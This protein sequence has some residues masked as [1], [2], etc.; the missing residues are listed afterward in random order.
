MEY[1]LNERDIFISTKT[2]SGKSLCYQGLLEIWQ[3]LQ[4]DK[5]MVL[6]VSPLLAIMHEQCKYLQSLGYSAVC[7]GS[8]E[9]ERDKLLSGQYSFIY[10]SP[11]SVVGDSSFRDLLK[12]SVYRTHLG[13]VVVDEAHTVLQW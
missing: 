12:S 7:L 5:N 2:G 9:V 1:V 8:K 3:E 13:Y 6:V 10:G 11:E 4:S